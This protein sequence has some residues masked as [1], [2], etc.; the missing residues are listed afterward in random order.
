MKKLIPNGITT[1]SLLSGVV[2][3]VHI[4]YG[5]VSDAYPW[6]IACLV[7]DGLDGYLARKLN[8]ATAF[9]RIFDLLVDFLVFG[10]LLI[11]FVLKIEGVSLLTVGSAIFFTT[12]H[13]VRVSR[14]I[15]NSPRK[16]IGAPDT[17]NAIGILCFALCFG[18][19][20]PIRLY[21][22]LLVHHGVAM[23]VP[24]VLMPKP[25]LLLEEFRSRT[26]RQTC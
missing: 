22:Y 12:C 19:D 26:C 2:A 11:I 23:V 4:M 8:A 7:L 20:L 21:W 17:V 9:G 25:S 15:T 5:V 16:Y 13:V 10:V 6:M 14:L 24:V 18:T 3:Y 1:L